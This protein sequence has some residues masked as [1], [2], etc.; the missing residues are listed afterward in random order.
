MLWDNNALTWFTEGAT[1]LDLI[2]KGAAIL[3]VSVL[4]G[5]VY[6]GVVAYSTNAFFE[7]DVEEAMK[8]KLPKK[9][10]QLNDFKSQQ[11]RALRSMEKIESYLI[12]QASSLSDVTKIQPAIALHEFLENQKKQGISPIRVD[13]FYLGSTIHLW[14]AFYAFMGWL[15]F[16]FPPKLSKDS[17]QHLKTKDISKTILDSG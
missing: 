16:L 17:L 3:A 6:P 7:S 9:W 5:L 8:R 15:I 13:A 12:E 1:P 4:F 2:K 10:D 14:P 11:E